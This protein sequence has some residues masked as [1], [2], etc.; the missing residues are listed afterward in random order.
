MTICTHPGVI[1][2]DDGQLL[3]L[4]HGAVADE[5]WQPATNEELSKA[6]WLKHHGESAD[7]EDIIMR[8]RA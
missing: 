2:D 8:L 6:I 4:Y 3:C 5:D 7:I 1:H